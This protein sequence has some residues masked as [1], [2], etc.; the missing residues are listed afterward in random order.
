[1]KIELKNIKHFESG[2]EET[3][4]FTASLYIDGKNAGIAKN[5]GRG[6]PTHYMG[7]SLSGRE[8]IRQAEAYCKTLPDKKYPAEHG[9][10]AFSVTMD[11]ETFIDDLLIAHLLDKDLKKFRKQVENAAKKGIVFGIPD[12]SY[13][14]QKFSIPL[15]DVLVHPAGRKVIVDSLAKTVFK[16]L[17][18]GKMILNTNIPE[19]YLREAGLFKEQYV[20]PKVQDAQQEQSRSSPQTRSR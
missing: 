19:S 9:M 13:M 6:G 11:L 17:K 20:T 3:E 12:H 7:D 15:T 2:S 14:M 5:E 1:M 10:E 8:L 16:H 4:C 18:D